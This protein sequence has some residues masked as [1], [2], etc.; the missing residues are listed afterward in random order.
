[1][2]NIFISHS[3]KDR[4][5]AES[6][7]NALRGHEYESLF[8]SSDALDGIHAGQEWEKELY[9]KLRTSD[10]VIFI[11]SSASIR[12]HWCFAEVAIARSLGKR[13]FPIR[14]GEARFP[15]LS[16]LQWVQVQHESEAW[17]DQLWPELA[18][19]VDTLESLP[20]RGD[21]PY[22]GLAP[23]EANLAGVFFGRTDDIRHALDSFQAMTTTVPGTLRSLAVVGASGSGKSS[24]LRA[25]IVPRLA[26]MGDW[27]VVP[28]FM[29]H[30]GASP[31]EALARKVAI[32]M[33]DGTTWQTIL[34]R[35][36]GA[37]GQLKSIAQDLIDR[38]NTSSTGS[39]A[40]PPVSKLLIAVD[41]AEE[42]FRFKESDRLAFL[43][44]V[45]DALQDATPVCLAL[46][47]RSEFTVTDAAA[48]MKDMLGVQLPLWPLD[49]V[50]LRAAIERPADMAGVQ[51]E[52]GLVDRILDDVRGGDA[53][54]LL[55]FTLARLFEEPRGGD[56]KIS[57]PTYERL[58]GVEGA[59]RLQADQAKAALATKDLGDVVLP[60]LKRF[61]DVSVTGEVVRRPVTVAGLSPQERAV[62]DAFV[63]ARLL[64]TSGANDA[65]P[66]AEVVHEALFRAW[67]P[68]QMA[69]AGWKDELRLRSNL[70]RE[71]KEWLDAG[72]DPDVLY[73]GAR[74]AQASEWLANVK[75]P[76]DETVREFIR[77]CERDAWAAER[78]R[79]MVTAAFGGAALILLGLLIFVFVLRNS[80]KRSAA[81]AKHQASI[82]FSRELA[83]SSESNLSIDPE[84]SLLLA[85][86]AVGQ[87]RTR[88]AKDALFRA[89]SASFVRARLDRHTGPVTQSSFSPDGSRVVTASADGTAR[90]WDA[91]TG[92]AIAV[93][94][95]V[96]PAAIRSVAFSPDSQE[97]VIGAADGN[98]R[99]LSATTGHQIVLLTKH[100]E[101]SINDV[102]F[103]PDGSEVLTGNQD[104]TATLW[105]AETGAVL[106][107]FPRTGHTGAVLG[108]SFSPDGSKVVTASADDM[109]RIW[110]SSTGD[111]EQTLEGHRGFVWTAEF[112]RDGQRVVTAS[113][114]K[115]AG[116][117]DAKTGRNLMLLAG[118][119][120][121]VNTA[122]FSQNGQWI[123]TASQD[124]TARVWNAS[125]GSLV[126]I[127][128]GHTSGLATALFSP[129]GRRVLTASADTTARIWDAATGV[130]IA[131]LRGHTDQ[132][133]DAEFS[134][135]GR[136]VVTAS[137]D[138]TARIWD[139][140]SNQVVLGHMGRVRSAA[141][142][143]DDTWVVTS[144]ED[145]T[146]RIWN[147]V[148]GATVSTLVGHTDW[149][150]DA[151]FSPDGERVVTASLDGTARIWNAAS[152]DE[153]Q[154]LRP[155]GTPSAF[156]K[157]LFSP[158]GLDVLTASADRT[159][160]LWDAASGREIDPPLQHGGRVLDA[161]FNKDGT[162]IVTASDD[163]IAY[164]WDTT[165]GHLL[166]RLEG[167]ADRVLV[168]NFSPDGRL[169]VTA[170]ADRTA[171]VWDA[172]TGASL[173]TLGGSYNARVLDAGFSPDGRRI[174]TAGDDGVA[175]VWE[176]RTGSEVFDLR[177][178]TQAVE[179][180]VFSPDGRWIA[181]AGADSTVRLWD[182]TDGEEVAVLI[183]HDDAVESVE[184]SSDSTALVT[185]SNDDTSR[186]FACQ[187]V[188]VPLPR[189][190]ALLPDRITRPLTPEERITYLHR[191]A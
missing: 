183:G 28:T 1:M 38:A 69:I 11:A 122:E 90:V 59:L 130:L 168:A 120:G 67:P 191:R 112:S 3:S 13:I 17:L 144:S 33:D 153:L 87:S 170:S 128:K 115:T 140:A 146:A 97:V 169:V 114:D 10:A 61:V 163:K 32:C 72:R 156:V 23:F 129:D 48:V 158:D 81:E 119:A 139:A 64:T 123:V 82:A 141:F 89:L 57:E 54:P 111:L 100:P 124:R 40:R 66:V 167:H 109:A 145:G 84:L 92:R 180:A 154:V 42:L 39:A 22:P 177:G 16:G 21:N 149:V 172:S 103:S 41:Q 179:A 46:T 5:F 75:D 125:N 26:R 37:P 184:F 12:S 174:V 107:V 62:V 47:I 110:S 14:I 98:A 86:D 176:A 102:R 99:I 25:G 51:F 49:Q 58:G 135:D 133:K 77:A 9:Q 76:V 36:T 155:Q 126:S 190:L 70:Q 121:I 148:T 80:A 186:V 52:D 157:A 24:L 18:R 117:W 171:R 95:G 15:L 136:D 178:N 6:L 138:H 161:K 91:R 85:R 34:E 116:V 74:L 30:E 53:L 2:G 27:V 55:A 137:L 73:K 142:S 147:A 71:A 164:V 159:A 8:L 131:V 175:R 160:R 35:L 50:Q 181:T 150:V 187:Q 19:A 93:L 108:L 45:R 127:M 162:K 113:S 94:P 118:H 29:P 56:G 31:L 4:D 104:G 152:G 189:L 134:P 79:R 88:E 96:S 65:Q 132:L 101:G 182:A 83:S 7:V 106:E 173:R 60:T 78:R 105:I 151:Q 166:E 165:D 43:A 44:A 185:A 143:P 68:L 188:C 20:W 63:Q